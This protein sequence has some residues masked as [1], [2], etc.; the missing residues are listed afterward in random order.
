M[1]RRS[2]GDE[3]R[4]TTTDDRSPARRRLLIEIP[5]LLV[6]AALAAM[7]F[8]A[9]IAQAF[10]VEQTSMVPQLESGDRVLVSKVSYR[11]HD[12]RRG[13]IVV[14]PNPTVTAPPDDAAL[15]LRW[16]RDVLEGVGVVR[17]D[18]DEL[19]KRVVGLPGE[20][21]EAIDGVIHIDGRP[22]T[23]PYLG[24]GVVTQDFGVTEV[25]LGHVFV[26]GD[27][28]SNSVDSRR[29]GPVPSSTLD[30]RAVM[31]V[32]PPGRIQYL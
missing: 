14:F 4:L 24:S 2:G 25:P 13:D 31:V 7:A 5:V 9:H 12:P 26:L 21:V 18:G 29:F 3:D 6:V 27:N 17:P 16:G 15:P 32:W 19:I 22:L 10:S 30:G 8:K 20:T 11:L 23:E 28:R 1:T